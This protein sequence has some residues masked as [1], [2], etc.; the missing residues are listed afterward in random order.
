VNL[1]SFQVGQIPASVHIY[2]D[3]TLPTRWEKYGGPRLRSYEYSPTTHDH[4]GV[5]TQLLV[6]GWGLEVTFARS[7]HAQTHEIFV[8][9]LFDAVEFARYTQNAPS[10]VCVCVSPY[11]A[12]AVSDCVGLTYQ[13][14]MASPGNGARAKR[15]ASDAAPKDWTVDET[16]DFIGG[17]RSVPLL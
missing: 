17:V 14:M 1:S 9:V 8:S 15:P 2:V 5:W 11:A 16:V 3:L 4:C 7:C 10:V 12:R 13:L 6:G